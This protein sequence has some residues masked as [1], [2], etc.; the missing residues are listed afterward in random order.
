MESALSLDDGLCNCADALILMATPYADTCYQCKCPVD[1]KTWKHWQLIEPNETSY[2]AFG[3]RRDDLQEFADKP[4]DYFQSEV[5]KVM[6]L[7]KSK[8]D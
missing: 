1:V 8:S 3:L 6:N 5:E 7:W 4:D 2:F